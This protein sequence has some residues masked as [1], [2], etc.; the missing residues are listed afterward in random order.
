MPSQRAERG[1][2]ARLEGRQGLGGHPKVP[3]G[4]GRP[5]QRARRDLQVLLAGWEGSGGSPEGPIG[6]GRPLQRAERVERPSRL[7]RRGREYLPKGQE[8]LSEDREGSGG[9]PGGTDGI[10]RLSWKAGK[11]RETLPV[12]WVRSEVPSGV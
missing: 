4:V 9:P 7:A 5:S 11:G 12:G 10:V 3:G 6:V 8:S 2:E 1:W